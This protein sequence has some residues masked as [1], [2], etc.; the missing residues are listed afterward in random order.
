MCKLIMLSC[1]VV[2]GLE[3]DRGNEQPA[4]LRATAHECESDLRDGVAISSAIV[5]QCILG[6]ILVVMSPFAYHMLRPRD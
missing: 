4:V 2:D 6:V 1:R 5:L 3:H